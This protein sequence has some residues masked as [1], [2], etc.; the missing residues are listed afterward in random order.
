MQCPRIVYTDLN[1]LWLLAG[2]FCKKQDELFFPFIQ[3]SGIPMIIGAG[4][5]AQAHQHTVGYH[6]GD[7][8]E[9]HQCASPCWFDSAADQ[10]GFPA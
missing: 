3:M 2:L 7:R 1:G 10:M 9:V 8:T 6:P 4:R 5:L